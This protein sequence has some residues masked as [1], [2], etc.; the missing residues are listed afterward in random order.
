M[1]IT[2]LDPFDPIIGDDLPINTIAYRNLPDGFGFDA[3]TYPADAPL[4][5]ELKD[6]L[7]DFAKRYYRNWEINGITIADWQIDLQ[8]AL[9]ENIDTMEK[10]LAVYTDDIAK[11]TQSRTIKRIYD[12][13]DTTDV[14]ASDSNTGT[15]AS[16]IENTDYDLPIDNPTGQAVAKSNSSG[17]TT[18]N[19][20]TTSTGK[21]TYG[22]KGTETEEWSDVGVA[23][24][25]IL[26]NGFLDNNRTYYNVFV[27]FFKDCFMLG[28][29]YYG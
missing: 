13:D 5:Y 12:I 14:N 18:N 23:P 1:T 16:T 22:H 15:V 9:N 8:L 28:E 2:K 27:N 29:Y 26:L 4:T 21:T 7:N 17:T 10:M 6:K 11:P 19:L 3:L 25:Y 24:N 20:K